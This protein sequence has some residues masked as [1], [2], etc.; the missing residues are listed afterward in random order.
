[1]FLKRIFPFSDEGFY[2]YAIRMARANK[3][4]FTGYIYRES[5]VIY[6]K[7]INPN[8]IKY[9][10]SH[11]NSLVNHVG[12]SVVEKSNFMYQTNSTSHRSYNVDIYGMTFHQHLILKQKPKFCPLCMQS[13]GYIRNIWQFVPITTC[14]EHVCMLI[15][16]CPCCTKQF[17]WDDCILEGCTNCHVSWKEIAC[18]G[19]IPPGLG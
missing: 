10:K 5:Q 11:E 8:I 16:K 17:K 9:E 12:R 19:F 14:Y 4:S 13:K 15:D 18:H 3:L 2:S 7:V 1:M 6:K